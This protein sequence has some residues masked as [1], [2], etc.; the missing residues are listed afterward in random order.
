MRVHLFSSAP[1]LRYI[2]LVAATHRA[3]LALAELLHHP[4]RALLLNVEP[5]DPEVFGF[6][7]LLEQ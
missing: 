3:A 1:K 5:N 7:Q 4:Q 6:D 2:L